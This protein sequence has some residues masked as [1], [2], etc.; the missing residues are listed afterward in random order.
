MKPA[1]SIVAIAAI[2]LCIGCGSSPTWDPSRH[3]PVP[4]YAPK[5]AP[6]T[7]SHSG[8]PPFVYVLPTH[9]VQKGV[10][11]PE[12]RV[13]NPRQWRYI[14]IHHS[15]TAEDCAST[16]D[17]THRNERGWDC[18]GYDFVINNG[19]YGSADG[20]VEVGQR[21]VL[22]MDGAHAGVKLYNEE[23]IGVVLVGNFEQTR[24]T[25]EQMAAAL[26]LV[27]WLQ[28][29]YNI[30]ASNVLRHKDIKSTLCPGKNFPWA[31]FKS[32]LR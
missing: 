7:P 19:S 8:A 30:P 1:I 32:K 24:P 21:W 11:H 25:A 10:D 16:M 18:L 14:I 26:E 3:P 4:A 20:G 2:S 28:K 22:Q 15:A 17:W 6:A 9:S 13:T 12:W 31:D 5:T 23:G 27:R 29:E